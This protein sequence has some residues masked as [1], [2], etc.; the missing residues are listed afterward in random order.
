MLIS[1][2][3][4][5]SVMILIAFAF[6]GGGLKYI[7]QAYDIAVFSK[8]AAWFIA[9]FVGVAMG[10]TMAFDNYSTELLISIILGVAFMS[11]IDNW[12]FRITALISLLILGILCFINPNLMGSHFR[13]LSVGI[14][15]SLVLFDEFLDDLSDNYN[16]LKIFRYRPVLEISIFLAVL[17]GFFPIISFFSLLSF[18]LT[19]ILVKII[20]EKKLMSNKNQEV[21]TILQS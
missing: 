17:L 9:G 13:W 20:S 4:L 16:F 15:T 8:T 10:I 12:P 7:D 11:K 18:D 6:I 21:V 5:D 2:E 1:N 3:Y 19:Y 14:L